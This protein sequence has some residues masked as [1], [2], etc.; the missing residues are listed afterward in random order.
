MTA[1]LVSIGGTVAK[2]ARLTL[3]DEARAQIDAWEKSDPAAKNV[4][5]ILDTDDIVLTVAGPDMRGSD[6]A[7]LCMAAAHLA[8]E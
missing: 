6:I 8:L 5:L 1:K 2:P 4:V 7:G 3:F